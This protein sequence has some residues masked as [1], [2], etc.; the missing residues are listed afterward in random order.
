MWCCRRINHTSPAWTDLTVR[1]TSIQSKLN[2]ITSKLREWRLKIKDWKTMG[3][4]VTPWWQW[5]TKRP[6]FHK[7]TEITTWTISTTSCLTLHR[8]S[9]LW[10]DI[11]PISRTSLPAVDPSRTCKV[12]MPLNTE[13][14]IQ[15]L[16]RQVEVLWDKTYKWRASL[17]FRMCTLIKI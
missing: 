13:I 11:V 2:R 12:S 8:H 9:R 5:S 10:Q 3:L 15:A 6:A 7:S 14:K 17:A 16:L 4:E 1:C